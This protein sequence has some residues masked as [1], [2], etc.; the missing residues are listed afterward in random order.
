MA[1]GSLGLLPALIA[2]IV[3]LGRL[4]DVAR[5]MAFVFPNL[6]AGSVIVAP[7]LP[8]AW[9]GLPVLLAQRGWEAPRADFAYVSVFFIGLTVVSIIPSLL[10]FV[11]ALQM[12]RLRLY[13]LAMIAAIMAML[14]CTAGW[15]IGLPMGIWALVVLLR[16]DVREAFDT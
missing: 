10:I 13:G 1:V 11:G 14:P 6:P 8:M 2:L 7:P 5:L 9:T 4:D 12:R 15:F 16:P 3:M